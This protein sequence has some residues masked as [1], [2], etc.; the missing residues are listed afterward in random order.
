MKTIEEIE[1]AIEKLPAQQVE[2][3]ANWLESFQSKRVTAP[4][5]DSWLQRACGGAIP[6]VNTA[7]ILA[8]TRGEE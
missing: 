8:I 1:D 7:N 4:Y 3:L 5:V 6:G 2:E